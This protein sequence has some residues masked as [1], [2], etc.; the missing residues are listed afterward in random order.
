MKKLLI[1][2]LF[3]AASSA[4]AIILAPG[5]METRLQGNIDP[6][7]AAGTQIDV[8]FSYGYFMADNFQMGFRLSGSDNDIATQYGV[9]GFVEYNF[10][11]GNEE[12]LP[13]IEAGIGLLH[14]DIEA[15]DN[16]TAIVLTLSPGLKYFIAPNV[17][18]A[19]ALVGDA[20]SDEVFPDDGELKTSDITVEFSIRFYY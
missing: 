18:V 13:F 10:D 11:L 5:T 12:W 14:S 19:G 2:A 16:S 4:H 8:A 9:G 20:A 7:S 3:A 6:T 1:A 17:C 15:I